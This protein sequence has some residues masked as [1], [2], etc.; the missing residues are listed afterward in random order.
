M[1]S[2]LIIKDFII[3]DFLEI[4][5]NKGFS[6]FTGETG[7]GKSILI[8]ALTFVLGGRGDSEIVKK[9]SSKAEICAEFIIN[10]THIND[11]LKKNELYLEDNKIILR[12]IIDISGR[13]RSFINGISVNVSQLKDLGSNLIHIYG[14][15][16]NLALF[17]P[18][19]QLS[20]IDSYGE[21]INSK[22]T[23]EKKFYDWIDLKKKR[24]EAE[25]NSDSLIREKEILDWQISELEKLDLKE[26][27][28][29]EITLEHSKLSNIATLIEFVNSSV[30]LISENDNG[31][32]LSQINSLESKSENLLKIDQNLKKIFEEIESA[33]INLQEVVY[34]LKDYL[35]RIDVDPGR[36]SFLESR[37]E[38][39]FVLSRKLKAK[40]ENLH[41]MYSEKVDKIN[42]LNDYPDIETLI[43][44][45]EKSENSYYD[46]AYKLSKS[47]KKTLQIFSDLVTDLLQKL[48][49]VGGKFDV[50]CLKTEPSK[51]GIDKIEF[52]VAGHLGAEPKSLSKV[53]SG[54]EL[55]RISLA[56]SVV[57][58]LSNSIPTIIFDEVDS[59]VG[60]GVAE[61]VGRLLKQLGLDRQVLC[62]TH[63]PQVASQAS[64]HF[65]VKKIT[66]NEKTYTNVKQL[67]NFERIE[68]IARMLGGIEITSA[69]RNHAKELLSL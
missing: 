28:W 31:S 56:I 1:L 18:D 8:D 51:K 36:L 45:E 23:L 19:F 39:I 61:V 49:M 34:S 7:A 30:F 2:H 24:Q 29:S 20:L 11:W 38:E 13:S 47:R 65:S 12:R 25:K 37:I 66:I 69:T 41:D 32:L 67:E 53:A 4:E 16:S 64:H 50:S 54:G 63:L 60:G 44:A 10:K 58:S 57:A 17:K 26:G 46:L 15:N 48:S 5:F 21:L 6:V 42:S 43:K 3:I 14:Q 59:G 9:N 62:V 68:E 22:N 27:E 40:P 55:S 35:S 33:R 52:K